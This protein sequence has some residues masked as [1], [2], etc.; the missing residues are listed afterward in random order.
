MDEILAS[1]RRIITADDP[2]APE[3]V[4]T[5]AA[6]V[7]ETL[8]H[9]SEPE[10]T[11]TPTETTETPAGEATTLVGSE[12]V[13]ATATSFDRLSAAVGVSQ[14]T[15]APGLP[16]EGRTLEDLTADLLRPM[17]KAWLDQ[18]LPEIVRDQVEEEVKRIARGRVR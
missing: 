3:P 5:L 1:I 9:D 6:E 4:A 12:T 18:N 14:R 8:L 13:A 15:P 7:P 16:P 2:P 17:L 11:E 10:V